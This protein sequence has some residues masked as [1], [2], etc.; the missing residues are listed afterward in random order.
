MNDSGIRENFAWKSGILRFGIWSSRNP[1][2]Y[3]RLESRIQVSL[4]KTGIQP[5]KRQS[6]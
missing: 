3:E 4:T 6:L 2:S 5:Q 1:E